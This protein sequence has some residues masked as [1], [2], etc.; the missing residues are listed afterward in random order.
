MYSMEA[1]DITNYGIEGETFQYNADGE[2]E[3]IADYVKQFKD[4]SP[5]DYYACWTD[6]G[7]GKLDFSMYACNIKTQ[8][9]I[10]MITGSWSD[11][12]EDYWKIIN[13][14]DAYVQ[15]H[16]AP[17]FT[18]EEADRVKELTT[19]LDTFFTQEYDKYI[20]G[21]ESIDNWD[22]L[23]KKAEDMGVKELEQLW[24]DAEARAVAETK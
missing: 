8:R 19:D 6:I 21:K 4:A 17:S 12:T 1:S 16:I 11:L 13:E 15:P 24:N 3:Y 22:A 5:S 9:E 2:A 10:Q 14:D 7:A 18:T 23:I 20:T